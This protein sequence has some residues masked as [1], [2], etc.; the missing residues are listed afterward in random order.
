[1]RDL[2]ILFAV[3][4]NVPDVP[5]CLLVVPICFERRK[6]E[7][8]PTSLNRKS[9]AYTEPPVNYLLKLQWLTKHIFG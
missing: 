5:K 6:K 8:I 4:S 7:V 1:M 3:Y 9:K 2:V